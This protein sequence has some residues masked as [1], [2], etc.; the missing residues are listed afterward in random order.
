MYCHWSKVLLRPQSFLSLHFFFFFIAIGGIIIHVYLFCYISY[1]IC[2]IY[3]C[4]YISYYCGHVFYMQYICTVR[5]AIIVD[6]WCEVPHNTT[7]AF[8]SS[9]RPMLTTVCDTGPIGL[10]FLILQNLPQT[11]RC[12]SVKV[13]ELTYHINTITFGTLSSS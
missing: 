2:H 12:L 13:S 9:F 1:C 11:C 5:W 10:F 6:S 4:G 3:L 7:N 8:S